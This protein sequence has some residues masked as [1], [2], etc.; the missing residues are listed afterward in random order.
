MTGG[1]DTKVRIWDFND[2][3]NPH[4]EFDAGAAVTSLAF[5][6]KSA[7]VAIGTEN[8][9]TLWDYENKE[10]SVLSKVEYETEESVEAAKEA[11][12]ETN[13]KK[14][15]KPKKFHQV[16]SIQWNA[17][18]TRLFVGFNNGVIRVYEVQVDNPQ[19]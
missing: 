15:L 6:P 1:K 17:I 7:W 11:A 4:A 14:K 2:C 13:K 12:E 19:S 9:V 16:T 3:T 18:G 5:N 8:G 10:N